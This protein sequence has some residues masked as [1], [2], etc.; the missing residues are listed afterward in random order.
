MVRLLVCRICVLLVN[1]MKAKVFKEY[2]AGFPCYSLLHIFELEAEEYMVDMLNVKPLV[3]NE[4]SMAYLFPALQAR[5][6]V[7]CVEY[8]TV[9]HEIVVNDTE[10]YET[11]EYE[12]VVCDEMP[13]FPVKMVSLLQPINS[14]LVMNELPAV[15]VEDLLSAPVDILHI[16]LLHIALQ[17]LLVR[18]DFIRHRLQL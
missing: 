15:A 10:D 17:R 8:K 2:S 4:I 14:D 18:P 11:V 12:T 5:P 7:K 3:R 1:N 16:D 6:V 9:V 13:M